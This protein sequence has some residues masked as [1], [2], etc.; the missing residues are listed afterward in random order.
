MIE[1]HA[2]IDYG[3]LWGRERVNDVQHWRKRVNNTQH[4]IHL[5][6]SSTMSTNVRSV[7]TISM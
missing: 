7:A 5:I 1:T 2:D 4:C 3:V 6:E